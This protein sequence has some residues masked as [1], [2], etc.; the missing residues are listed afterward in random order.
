ME[1]DEEPMDPWEEA[2]LDEML[3]DV[4]GS[5]L[6]SEEESHIVTSTINKSC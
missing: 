3:W 2:W 5:I 4:V 6:F 1:E